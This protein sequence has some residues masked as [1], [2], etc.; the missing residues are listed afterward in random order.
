MIQVSN[1]NNK[2]I[3]WDNLWRSIS[4][5]LSI[6]RFTTNRIAQKSRKYYRCRGASGAGHACQVPCIR[7]AGVPGRSLWATANQVPVTPADAR[8]IFR[9]PRGAPSGDVDRVH[10]RR[11]RMLCR[12]RCKVLW[13]SGH[14]VLYGHFGILELPGC[15]LSSWRMN[16]LPYTSHPP[17]HGP[18]ADVLGFKSTSRLQ[19]EENTITRE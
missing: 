1:D 8:W 7:T 12:Q 11:R 3:P 10:A 4:T 19:S 18:H 14:A 15:L 2:D 13:D 16:T 5:I 6:L 9:R 17:L